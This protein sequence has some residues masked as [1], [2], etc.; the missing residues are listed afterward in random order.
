M[1]LKQGKYEP[2]RYEYALSVD[3]SMPIVYYHGTIVAKY[4]T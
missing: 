1:K 2:R 3:W 4:L